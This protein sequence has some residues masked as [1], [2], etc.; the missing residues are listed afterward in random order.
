VK[1]REFRGQISLPRKTQN[2]HEDTRKTCSH[3]RSLHQAS[4]HR[5]KPAVP[6]FGPGLK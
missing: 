4:G 6:T 1:V 2:E 3:D 5:L